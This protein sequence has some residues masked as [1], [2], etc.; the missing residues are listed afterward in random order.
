M[1]A[2]KREHV[3]ARGSRDTTD[4]VVVV[5]EEIEVFVGGKAN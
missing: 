1:R 2:M 4:L 5:E 3:N